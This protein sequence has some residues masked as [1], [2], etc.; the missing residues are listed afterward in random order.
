MRLTMNLTKEE[1]KSIRVYDSSFDPEQVKSTAEARGQEISDLIVVSLGRREMHDSGYPF[2]QIIG[3]QYERKP[4]AEIKYYDLGLHDHFICNL[5]VNIDSYGKNIFRVMPWG[6]K[7]W[8]VSPHFMP[9]SSFEIGCPFPEIQ[10][11]NTLS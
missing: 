11:E 3:R 7:K 1:V 8:Q 9:C 10:P 4:K 6:C 5:R 2:V